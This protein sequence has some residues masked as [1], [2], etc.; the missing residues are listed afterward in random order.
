MTLRD[1]F[2]LWVLIS[3]PAVVPVVILEQLA[4]RTVIDIAALIQAGFGCGIYA[5][6][7]RIYEV[8]AFSLQGS[9]VLAEQGKYQG[10]LRL[11]DTKSTEQDPSQGYIGDADY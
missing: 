11:Q 4:G 6:A 10:F 8:E 1:I 3:V 5:A 2:L 7:E 9:D